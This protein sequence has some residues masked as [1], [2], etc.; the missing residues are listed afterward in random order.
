MS[1]GYLHHFLF[2]LKGSVHGN[3][4]NALAAIHCPDFV[5]RVV[6]C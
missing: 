5:L 3:S 6:F 2:G 1:I 4:S